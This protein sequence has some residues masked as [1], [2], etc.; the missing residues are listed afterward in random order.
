MNKCKEVIIG[1]L[2]HQR[3]IPGVSVPLAV[4]FFAASCSAFRE[5]RPADHT[6]SIFK[7]MSP[8][9]NRYLCKTQENKTDADK[10]EVKAFC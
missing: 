5:N 4:F 1:Y 2:C 9:C 7:L 6:K 8:F 3:S 10:T